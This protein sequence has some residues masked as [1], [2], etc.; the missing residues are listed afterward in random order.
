MPERVQG[1][2]MVSRSIIAMIGIPGSINGLAELPRAGEHGRL[3][4]PS[5]TWPGVWSSACSSS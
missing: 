4:S 1:V 3:R 5:G 2:E